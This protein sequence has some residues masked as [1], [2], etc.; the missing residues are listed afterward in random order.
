MQIRFYNTLTHQVETFEPLEPPTVTMYN[1]GPTVYD[2]GH[3]GNFR[4]FLFADLLRRFLE[5]AGYDVRQVMNVTDVGHM[6]EDDLADGGGEDKMQVGRRRLKEAKKSG[7]ADVSDPDDPFQVAAFFT[8]A[9]IEDARRLRMRIADEYPGRVPRATDHIAPM[10]DLIRRLIEKGHAY[11]SDDGAVYYSVETFPDY[12]RLSGNTLDQLRG[13]AGGRISDEHQAQKR[14]PADFL[15]WKPDSGHLM[16]WDAPWG[17]GYPGWHIEC[18]A[19][20]MH[21]LGRETIDLHTGGEDNIFPH[22]E[23]EIAQSTGASGAPFARMWMHARFLLVDGEKMSKSRGNFYT[24][25]DLVDRGI[26]PVVIR[27]ELIKAPY[28]SNANLTLSDLSDSGKAVQRLRRFAEGLEQRSTGEAEVDL[29]HPVLARFA[30]ALADDL[31]IAE[32]LATVFTWIGED[33]PDADEALAVWRRIDSVLDVMRVAVGDD[34]DVSGRCRAIDDAR[35]DRDFDTADQLRQ[36][37]I[38]D[39]YEVMTT[40]EGTTARRSLT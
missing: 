36:G 6:T 27:Y 32:A 29:S 18:S 17:E 37:L 20:A 13:G 1:C 19:M 10:Q 21:L 3:I 7:V 5:L 28:R 38:D 15:L 31:N 11:V 35:R 9:F 34:D 40:Q 4:S 14:H 2:Y 25:R 33:P 22:H 23:C 8:G 26:D 39:G 30:G 24:V 12:G 16:K